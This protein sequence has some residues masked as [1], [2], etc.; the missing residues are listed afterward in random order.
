LHFRFLRFGFLHFNHELAGN[1]LQRL[2]LQRLDPAGDNYESL[3]G[4]LG[5][6]TFRAPFQVEFDATPAKEFVFA[7]K[8]RLRMNFNVFNLFNHPDFDAPNNDV[9]FFPGFEPPPAFP[10]SGSLGIIQHTLG[11]P[12]R[13]QIAAHLTF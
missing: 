2:R 9:S 5:R 8:Y 11:S 12:R 13:L 7:D 4:A 3:F 1:A 10:P 6:N